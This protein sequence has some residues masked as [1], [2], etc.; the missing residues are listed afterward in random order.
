MSDK[1]IRLI[2]SLKKERDTLPKINAFGNP[3]DFSVYEPAI[4]YLEEGTLPNNW[5]DSD[6][7]YMLIEDF[8]IFC[9]DY[10]IE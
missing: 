4:R 8:D 6:F 3:N 9:K 1:K 10:G 5:E 7:L 2:E